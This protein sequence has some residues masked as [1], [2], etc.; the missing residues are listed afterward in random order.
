MR[1][2]AISVVDSW[3]ILIDCVIVCLYV[4]LAAYM[5]IL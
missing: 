3:V 4:Y 2:I 5:L 1:A